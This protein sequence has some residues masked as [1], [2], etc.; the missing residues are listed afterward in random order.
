MIFDAE[1]YRQT[2]QDNKP[3]M[4]DI[5]YVLENLLAW[6]PEVSGRLSDAEN[7]VLKFLIEKTEAILANR[8]EA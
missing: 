4:D 7:A 6:Y 2:C 8:H 3:N 1:E 5:Y